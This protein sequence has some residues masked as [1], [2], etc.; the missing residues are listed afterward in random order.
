MLVTVLSSA[1]PDASVR[2]LL[3][4]VMIAWPQVRDSFGLVAV[5][6]GP[7]PST[8]WGG[9]RSGAALGPGID[10]HRQFFGDNRRVNWWATESGL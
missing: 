7:A 5:E 10:C 8:S 3:T 6:R 9:I 1:A 2:T 4:I